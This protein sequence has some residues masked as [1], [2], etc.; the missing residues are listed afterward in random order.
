MPLNFDWTGRNELD[1]VA[2]IRWQCYYSRGDAFESVK[3]RSD[4]GRF[5]DGDVCI[6]SDA[7]QDVGTATALSM[8]IHVRGRRLACQGVAWVGTAKSHRRR[9]A[10][11]K[12]VASQV[13]EQLLLKARERGE[14]VSALMPF[15]VSYY[16][17]FGFGLAERQ[18]VWTIPLS[19]LPGIA[20]ARW[21]FGSAADKPAMLAC[22][23]RQSLTGLCDV[24]TD[25]RALDE[26]FAQLEPDTQL[27][28][29]DRDG[30]I[31]AYTWIRTVTE[32]ERGI[33][34]TVQPSWE[35]HDA[36]RSVMS[37]LGSMRDQ[38]A[39]ARIVLPVD[40][41]VNWLLKERQVPHRPVEHPSAACRTI[42][43]MQIRVLD[44]VKFLQGQKII[45]PVNAS[46]TVGVR[47]CEGHCST[48]SMDL[49]SGT[50]E[51]KSS[52]ATP[53]LELEGV[54][55]SAIASGDLRASTAAMMGLIDVKTPTSVLA[56]DV[57]AEG[58]APF[59]YEYF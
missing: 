59:C 57:L 14:A 17:H 6:A 36:F 39:F 20:D 42:S 13:M 25:E 15:R 50:I 16:E 51:A 5:R 53:D 38:Y 29:D 21:R 37:L 45:R 47:E 58:Q 40:W 9:A 48:F 1:R 8:H 31:V 46:V 10:N 3:R 22:R 26:W 34:Q 23:A 52:T 55:W 54:T 35:S 30:R 56:L 19:I 4:S 11:E 49:S 7:G 32:N 2:R 24:E 18:N 27:F 44:H 33:A 28:V 43:R 12:G 41:P